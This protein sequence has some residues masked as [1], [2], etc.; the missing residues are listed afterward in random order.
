MAGAADN[1][2]NQTLFADVY[3]RLKAVA[4]KQRVRDLWRQQ[5]E[6]SVTGSYTAQVPG[7]GA[8]LIRLFPQ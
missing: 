3:S 2:F 8:K 6:A 5:D 1:L 4:G 7:H